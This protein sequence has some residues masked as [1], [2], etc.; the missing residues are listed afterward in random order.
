M[1]NIAE[2]FERGGSKE[3]IQY[4]YI[5]KGSCGEVRSQLYRALDKKHVSEEEFKNLYN[6]AIEASKLIYGLIVYLKNSEIK[7]QKYK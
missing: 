1:D 4:L 7:G 5:A 3:F 6:L 2:G